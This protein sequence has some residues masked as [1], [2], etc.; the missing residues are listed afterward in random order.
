MIEA[1]SRYINGLIAPVLNARRSGKTLSL[2]PKPSK[3]HEYNARV[4]HILQNSSFNDP[5]CNSWYKNEAGLITNNWSGT[6]VEYQHLLSRVDYGDYEVEGS[7]KEWV[8]GE[9]G[10]L[11]IG[12]VQEES[13]VSDRTLMIMGAVSTAA[14]VGGWVLRNSRLLSGVRVR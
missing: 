6:V 12:R 11:K 14:L 8:R 9:K 4:Q 1:Q 13:S 2:T 3:I 10:V 7:G 5:N